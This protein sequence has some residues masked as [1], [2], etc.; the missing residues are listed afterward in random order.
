M[1]SKK[2]AR[3][4]LK[5]RLVLINDIDGDG[6]KGHILEVDDS[7]YVLIGSGAGKVEFMPGES[8][9]KV[10]EMGQAFIPAGKV[11]FIDLGG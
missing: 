9:G 7:G 1:R 6:Y 4:G 3:D 2:T 10:L 11:K 8:G 5:G